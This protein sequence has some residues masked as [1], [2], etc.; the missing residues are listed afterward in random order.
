M[1]NDNRGTVV[2]KNEHRAAGKASPSKNAQSNNPKVS[3][4][5]TDY[6]PLTIEEVAPQEGKV[7][8]RAQHGCTTE[9]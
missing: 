1:R 6:V 8:S 5:S 4:H 2:N 3:T 7:C 9:I